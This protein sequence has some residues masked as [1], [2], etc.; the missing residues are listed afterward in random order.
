MTP[1]DG[2]ANKSSSFPCRIISKC[3]E[4]STDEESC[5]PPSVRDER[6]ALS[7]MSLPSYHQSDDKLDPILQTEAS[8][9][10]QPTQP[11]I[12]RNTFRVLVSLLASTTQMILQNNQP[13]RK[14]AIYE[15]PAYLTGFLKSSDGCELVYFFANVALVLLYWAS[16]VALFREDRWQEKYHSAVFV[17]VVVSLLVEC[18]WRRNIPELLLFVLPVTLDVCLVGCSLA[19]LVGDR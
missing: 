16:V 4:T 9:G 19:E 12:S 13:T 10:S 2:D 18:I 17:I 11:P 14:G 15:S 1:R 3:R 8:S 7:S 5:H 6:R